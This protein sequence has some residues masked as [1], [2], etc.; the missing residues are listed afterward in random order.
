MTDPK[1]PKP[2]LS[3]LRRR[4]EDM[5]QQENLAPESLSKGEADR[6]I[7][8]LR[9][10]QVELE[11]Q[12]EELRRAQV[13]LEESRNR[14]AELY[15]FAP[16]GYLTLDKR[17]QIIRANLTAATL[18]GVERSRLLGTY[19]WPFVVA[20]ERPAFQRLLANHLNL[21]RPQGEFHLQVDKDEVRP[22]LLN[23]S[24]Q[25][26]EGGNKI[27][28]LSLTDI[29][30]LKQ[31]QADLRQLTKRLL[32]AHEEERQ[33]IARDLHDELGQSLMA[34]K[35]Q[36]N[37]FKRQAKR[38]QDAWE[39]FDQ[40]VDF[41]NV[42]AKQVRGICQSL[43]PV[44]LENLGLNGA[45]REL[46]SEFQKHHGLEVMEEIEDLSGLFTDEV[47]IT[48]YRLFQECLTNAVRHGKA[49]SVKVRGQKGN[50]TVCFTCEDNGSGFDLEEAKARKQAS[51][52]LGLVAMKERVRL[53]QGTMAITSI[54]G[55]GTRITVSLPLDKVP[56]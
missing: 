15:D 35:M 44:A 9:V 47:Q 20:A 32:T 10:H 51:L 16:V 6:L 19:F 25:R 56:R 33:R 54:Q 27:S 43:R 5:M 22:V 55:Q 21:P 13:D 11:M 1:D 36:F 41:V 17:G 49:T 39:E 52:G 14:Y 7:H 48:V 12:N 3:D 30:E 8:E 40:A 45:L 50:G 34:L 24:F 38:G 2:D 42:I 18:L 31:A 26:D 46:L 29:T 28:R 4:A 23:L 37:A 53:L